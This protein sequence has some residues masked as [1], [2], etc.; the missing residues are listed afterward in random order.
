MQDAGWARQ[1]G[2]EHA[3]RDVFLLSDHTG[4]AGAEQA[5]CRQTGRRH[6][7]RVEWMLGTGAARGRQAGRK[8]KGRL[9]ASF[10][11]G[12]GFL[13]QAGWGWVRARAAQDGRA[14]WAS[15]CVV[16]AWSKDCARAARGKRAKKGGSS[17]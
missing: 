14:L 17:P 6:I 11:T 12:F 2:G 1:R 13:A 8:R 5:G 10:S 9:V 3:F 4:S 7:A 16:Q 15:A